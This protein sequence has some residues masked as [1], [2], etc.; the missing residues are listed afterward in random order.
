MGFPR[1]SSGKEYACNVGDTED[2]RSVPRLGISPGGENGNPIQ[3]SCLENPSLLC[4]LY[5]QM[6]SLPLSPQEAP[7]SLF[8]HEQR[9]L[10]GNSPQ[11]RKESNTAEHAYKQCVSVWI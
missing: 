7:I 10:V 9:I 8:I 2:A 3:Y 11:D 5:W 6:D 4:L 1:G